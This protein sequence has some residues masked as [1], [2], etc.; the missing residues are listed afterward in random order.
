MTPNR[1]ADLPLGLSKP[2]NDDR[3][4]HLLHPPFLKLSRQSRLCPR[5]FGYQKNPGGVFV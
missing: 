5:I 2:P 3:D 1:E 4:I